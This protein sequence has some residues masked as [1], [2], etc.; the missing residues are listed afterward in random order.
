MCRFERAKR[1]F[2]LLF[3]TAT[4]ENSP[5]NAKWQRCIFSGPIPVQMDGTSG[6]PFPSKFPS[7]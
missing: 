2:F 4:I 5:P 1:K 7:G 6:L 3:C